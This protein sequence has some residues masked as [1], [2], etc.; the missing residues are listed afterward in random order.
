MPHKVSEIFVVNAPTDNYVVD[1]SPFID[2]KMAALRAHVSQIGD[3]IE[4]LEQRLR[5]MNAEIGQP[6]GF[7]SAEQFHRIVIQ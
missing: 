6:H 2:L 7:A 4:E 1:I 5:A 3:H